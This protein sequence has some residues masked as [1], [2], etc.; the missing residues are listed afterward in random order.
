MNLRQLNEVYY[1]T[2]HDVLVLDSDMSSSISITRLRPSIRV[3][4]TNRIIALSHLL[5]IIL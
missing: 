5:C 1:V 4:P 3:R 2:N